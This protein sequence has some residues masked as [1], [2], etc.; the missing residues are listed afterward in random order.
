D[1]LEPCTQLLR[2][3]LESVALLAQGRQFRLESPFGVVC[4]TPGPVPPQHTQQNRSDKN[5]NQQRGDQKKNG[6]F[7]H[8]RVAHRISG[9][10]H[11]RPASHLPRR[12]IATSRSSTAS[13]GSF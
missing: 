5:A 4:R 3:P 1:A 2:T 7:T 12:N 11:C 10:D 13:S 8:K 6:S 9:R